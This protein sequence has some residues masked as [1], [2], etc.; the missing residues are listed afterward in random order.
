MPA[1]IVRC[2]VPTSTGSFSS[3]VRF[4][5]AL[6]G[7]HLR[8]AQFDLHEV[9]DRDALVGRRGRR[10]CRRC[11][12]PDWAR[13]RNRGWRVRA[14]EMTSAGRLPSAAVPPLTVRC[15]ERAATVSPRRVP[16]ASVRASASP[17]TSAAGCTPSIA[18]RALAGVRHERPKQLGDH[19]HAYR[20]RRTAP[21]RVPRASPGP[22]PA[23]TARA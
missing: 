4:R 10:T 17:T 8:D 13:C 22:S 7:Q 1:T 16:G 9:V 2:S 23:S 21:C 3:F 18:Q 11:G 19:A 5:H 6:G 12:A 15:A 20:R 14:L